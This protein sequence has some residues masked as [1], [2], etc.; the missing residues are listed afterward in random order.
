[1]CGGSV[2]QSCRT[3]RGNRCSGSDGV[4]VGFGAYTEWDF[5]NWLIVNRLCGRRRYVSQ[6]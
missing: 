2:G 6:G 5:K 4:I 1:V 3:R